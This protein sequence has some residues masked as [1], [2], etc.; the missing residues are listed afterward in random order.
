[1]RSSSWG[2]TRHPP[3]ATHPRP[4]RSTCHAQQQLGLNPTPTDHPPAPTQGA[5][6]MRSSSSW[7]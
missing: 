5:S 3:P 6:A 1:M 4:A 7:G 2:W